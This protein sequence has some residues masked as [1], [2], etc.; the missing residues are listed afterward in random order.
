MDVEMN[1]GELLTKMIEAKGVSMEE[2][3]DRIGKGYTTL[4]KMAK[5]C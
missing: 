4:W 5:R 2:V 3:A 1:R